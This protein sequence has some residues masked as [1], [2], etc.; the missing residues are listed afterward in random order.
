MTITSTSLAVTP[1]ARTRPAP[2]LQAMLAALML[3]AALLMSPSAQAHDDGA[4]QIQRARYGLPDRN[5][6]VTDRL[7]EIARKD[8]RV[9]ITNQLLGTD[10]AP[11]KKKTL[12]VY[13]RNRHGDFRTFEFREGSTIDGD[14][15]T[16]WG[17]GDWGRDS[18]SGGWDG[19][20]PGHGHDHGNNNGNHHGNNHDNNH[21]GSGNGP[22]GGQ[23][24]GSF[25][26]VVGGKGGSTGHGHNP[27]MDKRVNIVRA[28][29]GV[30]HRQVDVTARLRNISRGGPVDIVV[31]NDLADRDPAHG[32]RKTLRVYYTVGGGAER[33]AEAKE[34]DRLR[35]P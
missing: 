1:A 32:D 12:R 26:S 10:P 7:R 35:L 3:L 5:V 4:W 21:G 30:G 6:D 20:R 11:H 13:A 19:P 9:K 15:F 25:G 16:G 2:L 8:R 18:W 29:Y 23:D 34:R 22:F 14:K 24:G 28:T 33:V 27:G 31:S 17:R